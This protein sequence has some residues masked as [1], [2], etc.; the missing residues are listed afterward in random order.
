MYT[1]S[2][3]TKKYNLAASLL[4]ATGLIRVTILDTHGNSLCRPVGRTGLY[5]LRKALRQHPDALIGIVPTARVSILSMPTDYA[6]SFLRQ[7]R[8]EETYRIES[9]SSTIVVVKNPKAKCPDQGLYNSRMGKPRQSRYMDARSTRDVAV[10]EAVVA[11]GQEGA[12]N[13]TTG[14]LARLSTMRRQ[15]WLYRKP[16]PKKARPRYSKIVKE[17]TVTKTTKVTKYVAPEPKTRPVAMTAEQRAR[18]IM[19]LVDRGH[20]AGF[21]LGTHSLAE[22]AGVSYRTIANDVAALVDSGE[23]VQVERGRWSPERPEANRLGVYRRACHLDTL[24]GCD[25]DISVAGNIRGITP[26]GANTR[27]VSRAQDRPVKHLVGVA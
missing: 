4:D 16:K 8:M 11:P 7:W 24:R 27:R 9:G 14:D 12:G 19:R 6:V 25:S 3:I 21:R 23:L 20:P 22:M 13:H 10:L 5:H 26:V 1:S 18:M 17:K 2:S 15:C